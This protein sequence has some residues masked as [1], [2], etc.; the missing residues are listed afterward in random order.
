MDLKYKEDC[1]RDAYTAIWTL[2]N[3]VGDDLTAEVVLRALDNNKS[4]LEAIKSQSEETD[5][6]PKAQFVEGE[7]IVIK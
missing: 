2:K 3:A 7:G 1:I 5:F 6:E 4:L